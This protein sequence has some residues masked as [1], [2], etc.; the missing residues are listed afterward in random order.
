M[1]GKK[2]WK[3]KLFWV[4]LFTTFLGIIPLF[5][6]FVQVVAPD[7]IVLVDAIGVLVAGII[8]I[9]LRIWFTDQPIV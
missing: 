7:K 5:N 1:D 3:S 2:F 8:T 6:Q 9:V 4:G